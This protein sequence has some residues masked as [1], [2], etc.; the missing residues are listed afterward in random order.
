[1]IPVLCLLCVTLL[2][3]H[4]L[5]KLCP[6]FTFLQQLMIRG[7]WVIYIYP[8]SPRPFIDVVVSASD[9]PCICCDP[10]TASPD[11]TTAS[12][13]LQTASLDP[14]TASPGTKMPHP[15][16]KC[17]TQHPNC[18]TL[19]QNQLTRPSTCCTRLSNCLPRSHRDPIA[20]AQVKVPPF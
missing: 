9:D 2:V 1:M 5:I 8:C 15:G 11:S 3:L 18:F 17:L 20:C 4:V 19:Y 12:T 14:Q 10:S 13:D 16:P 7:L 6:A